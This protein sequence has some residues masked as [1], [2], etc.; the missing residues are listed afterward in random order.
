[1]M[2]FPFYKGDGIKHE[3]GLPAQLPVSKRSQLLNPERYIADPGL[4]DACNVALLLGQPLLITGDPGTGKTQFAYSLAWELGFD[5]PLKFE[6]KSTS[7]SRELFYTYDALKRFQDIQSGVPPSELLNYITYQALGLA[8]LRTRDP[9]EVQ[10]IISSDVLH[11]EKSR[12]IVLID[13][14][15]KAPRDFPNDLLN[16]LEHLYFRIPELKNTKIDADPNLQPLVII[17]SNSEKDL[18]EAFLR[19]CVYYH[20]PFPERQYLQEIIANHLADNIGNEYLEEVLKLFYK[21]RDP[22]SGLRKKPSTAELLVWILALKALKDNINIKDNEN[23][24][25]RPGLIASTLGS[26]IKTT[27]DQGKA[28]K[29]VDQWIQ[30]QSMKLPS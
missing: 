7:F 29:I 18:P 15:D 12:S 21:L 23:F 28:Q 2:K 13:E 24:L 10:E 6:V 1:M 17:T 5:L 11:L 19:R 4:K 26:L 16:E 27:E 25:A 20:I 8:I 3:D 30:E 14:I 22:V 9:L